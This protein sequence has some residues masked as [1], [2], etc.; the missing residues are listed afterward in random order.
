MISLLYSHLSAR[1]F[2]HSCFYASHFCST[3]TFCCWWKSALCC[4][5]CFLP[6]L[7]F[8]IVKSASTF[9]CETNFGP[10]PETACR[11]PGDGGDLTPSSEPIFVRS[12]LR[13]EEGG[14]A[15]SPV[16]TSAS[17]LRFHRA[18]GAE[19]EGGGFS[20]ENGKGYKPGAAL[21]VSGLFLWCQFAECV[22]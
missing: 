3:F 20:L 6:F 22:A 1:H 18:E 12:T 7:L 16:A 2:F 14:K 8:F 10:P 13:E 19:E 17:S 5:C 21:T 4:V 9:R 11:Q 15:S